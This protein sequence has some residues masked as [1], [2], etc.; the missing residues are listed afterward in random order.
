MDTMFEALQNMNAVMKQFVEQSESVLK[1]ANQPKLLPLNPAQIDVKPVEDEIETVRPMYVN[2]KFKSD[3]KLPSVYRFNQGGKRY[4]FTAENGEVMFYPSVTTIISNS[5]PMSYG[6]KKLLADKGFEGYY[7]YMREKA[8]YG[9]LLHILISDY[10]SSG[11]ERATRHFDFDTIRDRIADYVK[12]K[13]I[14]FSV[15]GWEWSIKKDLAS[16]IQFI[17]DY[18]VEP[19]AIEAVGVYNDGVFHYAGAI[20]LLCYMTIQE[21]GFYG[22]TYKSGEKKGTPKESY[23]DR[24]VIAVVDFKSGKS[25]FFEDHEIQLH[26]YLKMAEQSFG[27]KPEKV[28]NVAPK[29]WTGDTPTYEVKDQTDSD[30]KRKIPYLL[31]Q[32]SVDWQEP[33]DIQ[34]INGQVNG[35]GLND[36]VRLVSAKEYALAKVQRLTNAKSPSPVELVKIDEGKVVDIET[37]EIQEKDDLINNIFKT[38]KD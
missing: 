34:M 16:L 6:L 18:N 5:T 30:A 31:G 35:S 37:G 20:D 12:E 23:Q 15:S 29:D 7:A 14:N 4:Y 32:F 10:L 1:N 26:M 2:P 27:L 22:E 24:T 33:K 8:D 36:V 19:I 28:Y 13:R 25:G 3:F 17:Y 21:K 9:T 11:K 38:L